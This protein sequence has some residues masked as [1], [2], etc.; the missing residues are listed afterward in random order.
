ME[1]QTK[2]IKLALLFC[3]VFLGCLSFSRQA[4]AAT[5]Y[6][7]SSTGNDST[8][9]GAS[10]APYQTFTKGYA[11][12]TAG[13]IL[14]LTGTFDWSSAA[15]SGDATGSGFTINKNLTIQGQGPG[16]TFVQAS[17]T[18][19][20]ANRSVFTIASGRTV[21]IKNL[22]IRYGVTTSGTTGG[23]VTNNGTLTLQ[24]VTVSN[25][26]YNSTSYYGAGGIFSYDSATLVVS[27]STVSS[28]T[29]NGLY[30]GSGGIYATQSVT[31]TIT[32]ST[33]SGNA[34]TTTNPS[35]FPYSY[36]EP[37]GAFGVFRF[38]TIKLTNCTIT[39]NSTNAYA[40]GVQGYYDNSFIITNSTIVN[41][42]A[43]Q[44]AGG[45][46]YESVTGGYN[47]YLEN[48]ILADNTGN[49]TSSDFY[50]VSGSAGM[51]TD[52]GY[53]IVEFSTNKTF[54]ATG[55]ITG[56]QASLNI[57]S[58]LA[59][60]GS[61]GP[62]T[63]AL[64]SGSVAINAGTTT[65]NS[66]V[67]VPSLDQR[68][69]GR[70]GATDIGAFEYGGS[71]I[72]DTIAPNV[73]LTAPTAASAVSGNVSL[74][75]NS[76][77]NVAV[78]GITFYVDGSTKIGTEVT[79]TSSP[80]TYSNTWDSASVADGA[81]TLTAVSRDTSN[82]YAT[83]S[84]VSVTVVNTLPLLSSVT[85]SSTASGAAISWTSNILTSSLVNYGLTTAYGS[86]TPETNTSPRTTSHAITITGLPSCAKYHY[87]A[88][89]SSL[90]LAVATSTDGTFV[91][92]G[93]TGQASVSGTSQGT[94]S[95]AGGG[96][97]VQGTVSLTVPAGFTATTSS[98]IFQANLLDAAMFSAAAGTPSGKTRI[99]NT[100]VNLRAFIDPNTTLPSFA[101]PLTI[102]LTYTAQE[103]SGYDESTLTIYRYD[104]ASWHT[105]SGCSVNTSART[106]ACQTSAF[107]D[108]A[109]F[110]QPQSSSNNS[111]TVTPGGGGLPPQAY[112]KPVV[113]EGGFRLSVNKGVALAPNRLLT[114]NSNGGT[115]VKYIALST[116]PEFKAVGLIPYEQTLVWNLCQNLLACNDAVYTIYAKFYTGWGQQSDMVSAS[117]NLQGKGL[118]VFPV[119]A[120]RAKKR[121]SVFK[122]TLKTSSRGLEVSRLQE[123]LAQDATVYPEGLVTGYFGQLT[124]KAVQKFQVRY[125]IA[126]SSHPAFGIVG[127]MTRQRLNEL[128]AK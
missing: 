32:A 36:A 20:T 105:L 60:N 46:M 51:V 117:V 1:I 67:S 69:A 73:S 31:M 99:G 101:L 102:T 70:S 50:V 25:N 78:A 42:S 71:G 96:S 39:G 111:S 35:T 109:I 126:D 91:T 30:Y 43:G 9:S 107:S 89:G 15:E 11:S 3:L 2:D 55:D 34:A 123:V 17:S 64:L 45:V 95:A 63:L 38:G 68:A 48:N 27:T 98:A 72:P 47:M 110:G 49:A 77:D 116:D 90:A 83:S 41:N 103:V 94:I 6:V 54:S 62:Q 37:S 7:N 97:L 14:D 57:D 24:N 93:C 56:N 121:I 113:P 80:N 79:A 86:S 115:D 124:L 10:G 120:G 12:S 65:A 23:G 18:A 118:A 76:T 58:A 8:G 104:G 87:Q 21:T 92:L 84:G 127:P 74:T 5:V 128:T 85:A 52:N 88:Q 112:Y 13:D 108:F 26:S 16:Q 22:T 19:S 100:V 33:L 61:S 40:G 122:Q 125:G 53:N 4:L 59:A 75:A 44:G 106:V 119:T 114:I 81:H 82:N 66:T 28:N 29:F